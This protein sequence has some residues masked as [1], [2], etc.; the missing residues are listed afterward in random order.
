[1]HNRFLLKIFAGPVILLV[2]HI[3]ATI[4]GW[5]ET[6]YYL[7]RPMHFLGGIAVAMSAHYLVK[8]FSHTDKLQIN[9]KPIQVLA[10]TAV[11]ALGAVSWEFLEF[12][13][14]S[15]SFAVMQPSVYDTIIDL[16]MGLLGGMITALL[17]TYLPTANFHK[18]KSR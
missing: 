9:W 18:I 10:I 8:Y 12:Y 1:M 15:I 6:V 17:A 14:D 11:V 7:D 16:T 13:L 4:F 3:S 2:L 5:Y